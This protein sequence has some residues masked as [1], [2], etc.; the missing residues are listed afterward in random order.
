MN[1]VACIIVFYLILILI[2]PARHHA[3]NLGGYL[4][5]QRVAKQFTKLELEGYKILN[6]IM[7]P[8]SRGTSQIDHVILSPYGIFVIET[9]NYKG[10][11]YGSEN[12]E[13]WT[14]V[15]YKRKTSF[16]NPIKQNWGH[17]C[18]L[19]E[20][21]KEFKDINYISII[22]FAGSAELKRVNVK[23]DVFYTNELYGT[24]L[25]YRG[26]EQISPADLDKIYNHLSSI[27]INGRRSRRLHNKNIISRRLNTHNTS[28]SGICPKCKGNLILRYS[29]YGN[30]FGCS[31]YPK[32][33]YRQNV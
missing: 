2:K 23:T 1:L 27:S 5:E 15:I 11:I 33:I 32:C 19:K 13:N 30:F 6:D 10:W 22:I 16:R 3:P 25:S 4:G 12:S 9:K 14:Q 29:H 31:N 18:A 21:L 26:L 28:K 20:V 7:L 24:I 8:T 17:I